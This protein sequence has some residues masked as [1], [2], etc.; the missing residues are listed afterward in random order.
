MSV[1]K[2]AP[3]LCALALL[4][5]SLLGQV[6][7]SNIIGTVTDPGDASVPGVVVQLR[8]QGTG[9]TRA[10]TT[11]AEGI[12]RFTNLPP[13]TYTIALTAQG[14]KTYTQEGINLASSE[15]RDLGRIKLT[16]GA[17]TETVSVTAEVTPVQTASSEKSATIDAMQLQQIALKG[18]D[19][20]G[21]MRLIPGVVDTSGR[22]LTSP[23]AIGGLT[24]NGGGTKNFTVDGVT[25]LD[26]GCDNCVIPFEPNLD[27]ISEIRVLTSNYQA[28][29]GRNAGANISVITKGGGREFHGSGWWNKR[30]EMFNAMNFFDNWNKVPKT[31][32][33]FDV[34]GFTVGGPV[35]IPGTFN[36]DKRRLFFFVSEEFTKQRP[37]TTTT[38]ARVP[39]ALER[40]GDFSQSLNNNGRLL[41]INDPTT[42]KPYPGNKIPASA[43]DP[44]GLAIL[45]FFP[46]PNRRDVDPAGTWDETDAGQFYRRNYRS[47]AGGKHPRRNDVLR[48]DTYLTSKLSGYYRFANDFDDLDTSFNME[49]YSPSANKRLPYTEKH[50]N[51]GKG[52]AV[53][54]TYTISPT[55]VNEFIFGKTYNSWDWYVKYEDQ[56]A[57]SRM[58]N[59]P[60]W[61]SEND[62][63]F[64]VV[65]NRPG[66]NG[67]GNLNHAV[68][69]PGVS[70]GAPSATQTGFSHSRPYTNWNDIYSFSDNISKI[71]GKH[72]I[73]AGIYYE[74]T[75]K[76]QAESQGAYL[77][78]YSFGYDATSPADTGN[79][80]ANAYLGIVNSYSEGQKIVGDF[81]FTSIE[82][83]LQDNCRISRRLTLDV[84]VRFYR[85]KPWENLNKVSAVFL[86]SSYDPAKAPRLYYPGY[87]SKGKEAAVDLATG[88]QTY[89][90]LVGTFV[91]CSVGGYA[92]CPDINNGMEVADGKNPRVPFTLF[93]TP[94]LAYAPRIGFSWDVFGNGRT[95]VR[96]GFGQHFNRGDSNQIHQ[97]TRNPPSARTSTL[98]YTTIMGVG[99]QTSGAFMPVSTEQV[100]GKQRYEG[101][102]NGSFGIQQNV[103]FG[104]VLDASYV[105]SLRRHTPRTPNLNKIPMYSQY[106]PANIDPWS[107]YTPKRALDSNYLRPYRGWGTLTTREFSG[108]SNYHA[109]QVSVRRSFSRGLSY[110]LAYTWSKTMSTSISND[111]P[112]S[113]LKGPS[114]LAHVLAMNYIYDL[115]KLGRRLGNKALSAVLDGWTLSG[116]TQFQ[117]GGLFTP[118]FSWTGTTT[119]IPAPVM[120]GSAD[121]ARIDALGDPYLPKGER[122]F[123]RQFK[124]EMFAPPTPCS[125][126]NKTT[127]CFGNA[128]VNILTGPGMN[129]WDMT[130][131]K[132]IPLGLGEKRSLRFRAEMYNIWNQTQFSGLDTGGEW[133][134]VTLQQTDVNFGRFT[135]ARPPRQ[136]SMSLRFEF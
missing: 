18:R 54:I 49:L 67:L 52:H 29:Y 99:Q 75:G 123:W 14:F 103:G 132:E 136:M 110:G 78:S 76:A 95:A 26:T 48:L 19:L 125:W 57:R 80:I 16:L 121:G 13:G 2:L 111:F 93:S 135:S 63:A 102:M 47:I 131:A 109:L 104:T 128:G 31:P 50:P 64:K 100:I 83:Y 105:L 86:P 120:T 23:N 41:V 61:F 8:E 22:D 33:R 126:T 4:C 36:T 9:M 1:Q 134:V 5:G 15:N 81:W 66:G 6:V 113:R 17:L 3:F 34:Y 62:P 51:P 70:F 116:I 44:T 92:V 127:A 84:G 12:F 71:K 24:I 60:H 65:G 82:A 46:L 115:P 30:H 129:N 74:R 7:S 28:E 10:F 27:S 108:S 94:A 42:A 79:G 53:G 38:Y 40:Q 11:S 73:K 117:T 106:D 119:A 20:F 21:F 112:D 37:Q 35:Y 133:H 124:T 91:P 69:V 59:P 87:D 55:L 77:G 25:S 72:S 122:T 45:S 56:L 97:M 88:T 32:Y 114:G 68:Y 58:N 107:P 85:L 118:G 96:G 89:R 90:A 39:T 130:F 101:L 43:A 98:Y